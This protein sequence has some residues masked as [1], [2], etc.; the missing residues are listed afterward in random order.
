MGVKK[1]EAHV[2]VVR[3]AILSLFCQLKLVCS[4]ALAPPKLPKLPEIT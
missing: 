3:C 2:T 1:S 4:W